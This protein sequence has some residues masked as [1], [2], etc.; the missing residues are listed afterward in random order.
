[1]STKSVKLLDGS[2]AAVLAALEK[3][4]ALPKESRDL[5]IVSIAPTKEADESEEFSMKITQADD[6]ADMADA[7]AVFKVDHP[8]ELK[9][10]ILTNEH[11]PFETFITMLRNEGAM[12]TILSS[13]K[14]RN[15][16]FKA[17]FMD[18]Y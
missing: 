8:D 15:S 5:L 13:K 9:Q 10:W 18:Q 11:V 6:A 16:K 2:G 7:S 17:Q 3:F 4:Q 14:I 1:M 12:V